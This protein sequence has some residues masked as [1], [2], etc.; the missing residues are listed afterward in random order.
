MVAPAINPLDIWISRN[1][2]GDHVIPSGSFELICSSVSTIMALSKVKCTPGRTH[3]TPIMAIDIKTGSSHATIH[4]RLNF[5]RMPIPRKTDSLFTFCVII[6]A[7][8]GINI[9]KDAAAIHRGDCAV[10]P[11]NQ[12]TPT[13]SHTPTHAIIA[14]N[15]PFFICIN[16]L[17]HGKDRQILQKER[18]FFG[19]CQGKC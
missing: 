15:S 7:N 16:S 11:H 2:A 6:V 5:H 4:Q 3:A 1:T 10:L 12:L 13:S 9:H 18:H 17:S 19:C 14:N 8:K